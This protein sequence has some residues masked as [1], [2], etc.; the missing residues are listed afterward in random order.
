MNALE[1]PEY[2]A[3]VLRGVSDA[4]PCAFTG[5]PSYLRVSRDMFPILNG[6]SVINF[7]GLGKTG[8][9]QARRPQRDR[10]AAAERH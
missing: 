9:T 4:P 8:S 10:A 6:R 1:K 2:R 5:K 3:V 7:G